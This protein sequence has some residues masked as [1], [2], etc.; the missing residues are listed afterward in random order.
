MTNLEKEIPIMNIDPGKRVWLVPGVRTP[1]A[2]VDGGLAALDAVALSVPVAKAMGAQLAAGARPDLMVWGTVASNLGWSNIAREVLHRRGA[3]PGARPPSP[4]CSPAPPAWSRRSRR[5]A[6]W[7]ARTSSRW[8][9]A[10][11]A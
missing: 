4:P 1:F 11:R 8:S 2:R 3:R 7:A 9:A 10:W 6:C 5:R